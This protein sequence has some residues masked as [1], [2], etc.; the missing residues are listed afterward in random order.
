MAR[1]P[2]TWGIDIGKCGLKALRGRLAPGDPV[3]LTVMR[4]GGVVECAAMP[5]PRDEERP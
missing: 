2:F 4:A 3:R 1:S 5:R